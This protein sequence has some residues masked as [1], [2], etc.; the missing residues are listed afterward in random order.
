MSRQTRTYVIAAAVIALVF[1]AWL[2]GGYLWDMLLR[3][4]GGH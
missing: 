1:V 4:H 3:M 2:G